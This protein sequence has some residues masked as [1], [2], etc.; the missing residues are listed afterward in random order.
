M[1][2][3][4]SKKGKDAHFNK[5]AGQRKNMNIRRGS[6]DLAGDCSS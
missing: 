5:Q 4:T 3:L 6:D 2:T 1:I